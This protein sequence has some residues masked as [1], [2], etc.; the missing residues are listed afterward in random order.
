MACMTLKQLPKQDQNLLDVADIGPSKK[1]S[2]PGDTAA[3]LP[4]GQLI[5][6]S[7]RNSPA[8]LAGKGSFGPRSSCPDRYSSAGPRC[9]GDRISSHRK[10]FYPEAIELL[11]TWKLPLTRRCGYG[12]AMV[13]V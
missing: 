9:R 11:S 2:N 13:V 6:I 12:S 8:L 5:I 1:R 4:S 7:L 10:W 3:K